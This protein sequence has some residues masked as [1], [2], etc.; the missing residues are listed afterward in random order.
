ME[1]AWP[2]SPCSSASPFAR[3][4]SRCRTGR[5]S[6]SARPSPTGG[7]APSNAARGCGSSPAPCSS[8]SSP[9]RSIGLRLGF[10]DEGNLAEDTY[11]RQAYDLL[12]EGFGPGFNGP[13]TITVVPGT[14]DSVTAVDALQR[15]LADTPGVA[16]ITPAFPNRPAD[17][18]AF[19]IN[20][21]PATAPQ[22]AATTELVTSLRDDIIPAAIAGTGLDVTV[23][24]TAAANID[25]TDF[26]ARRIPVFFA[27]VLALS[28]LLLMVVFRSLLVPLKAVI[29]N[30][31]SI[32]ATYGV[33]VVIFQWGWGADLIGIDTGPIEAIVPL[34][35]FAIIFGLSM[36]YEVF[37][38]S[39][40]R[41]EYDKTGDSATAVADGLAKTAQVITAAAAIMVVVFGSF[42]FEDDRTGKLFGIGF[43]LAVL[44][45]A[46]I[47]RML[48]VPATMELLGD[49]NWWIPRWLD[50][51]IPKLN[52][53][54]PAHDRTPAD[55]GGEPAPAPDPVGPAPRPGGPIT[56]LP[57]VPAG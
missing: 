34:M 14:G 47:V 40:I 52:V 31:L 1:P 48:L 15:A 29:M 39:R 10:S 30:I 35:L 45:D 32:A 11:T 44:L 5:R 37:L 54:G 43:A 25:F 6:R 17:P 3:S 22:D 55:A 13:F 16:A 23:T 41:E 12:A 51:I 33:L 46:T 9:R 8:S 21:V 26:L 50:R 53:D 27:A 24:G 57:A 36:D 4:A 20:L 49:R 56:P 42:V 38:L 28:F 19:L 18:Q 7:A 2:R